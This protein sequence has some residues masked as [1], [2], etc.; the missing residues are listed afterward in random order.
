[1]T[2]EWIELIPAG[3]FSAVD[4][5][6]PFKND[7]PE[8]VI[9]A[10]IGKMPAAG[11]VVDYE[12]AT[13]LA[14]P[15]GLP[16]PAA[17]WIK[18]FKVAGGAIFARVEWT[19]DAAEMLRGKLYRYISPVFEHGNDGRIERILRAALTNNPALINLPALAA[20]K[21]IMS[22]RPIAF[23]A[24]ILLGRSTNTM[25]LTEVELMVCR[26]TGCTPEEFASAKLRRQAEM[27][28]E[29]MTAERRKHINLMMGLTADGRARI[30]RGSASS[31]LAAMDAIDE[32]RLEH[33][34]TFD[35]ERLDAADLID[36]TRK[37][38][39]AYEAAPNDDDAW[40]CLARAGAALISAL[41]RVLPAYANREAYGPAAA[42]K[43]LGGR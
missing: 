16:A 14:A 34:D 35:N 37:G 24:G 21:Q 13:D 4:G 31:Q 26:T 36:E 23:G 40:K 22:G 15:A 27:R 30:F 7:A 32:A 42:K 38:I 39:E 17:G 29:P 11:L 6:G 25:Q 12:H 2:T 10:S 8:R 9:A 43:R 20:S 28:T 41:G 18:Q 19:A 3:R 33:R 5:R 1:V